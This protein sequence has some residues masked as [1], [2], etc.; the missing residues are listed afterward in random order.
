MAWLV[1][2]FRKKQCTDKHVMYMQVQ[3]RHHFSARCWYHIRKERNEHQDTS[4]QITQPFCVSLLLSL[5]WN[6]TH[7]DASQ[8]DV[9]FTLQLI[10]A[11]QSKM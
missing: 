1:L 11:K 4:M 10:C 8:A 3:F 7:L 5:T 2:T 6:E 9:K